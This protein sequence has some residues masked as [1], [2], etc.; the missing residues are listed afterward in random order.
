MTKNEPRWDVR[1]DGSVFVSHWRMTA[2]DISTLASVNHLTL[3]NVTFPAAFRFAEL[4]TLAWLDIRGGSRH[5]LSY[6]RGAGGLRGL[7]INQ[8]RGL[9]DLGAI[10]E[11]TG[12][13]V[14]ALY[15]LAQVE[16]LPD[17]SALTSL[18][19][20]E[21]GQLR[22]LQDWRGLASAPA[23]EELAFHNLLHPDL[24]VIDTLSAHPMLREFDWWA[25]DVPAKVQ[26]S[27]QDRLALP[28]TRAIRPEVW[29]AENGTD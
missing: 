18:R 1:A 27:V 20:L 28:K 24:G 22:N 26:A 23:L 12:L 15:G 6:L 7:S 10:S 19:R 13:R 29:F 3:W 17:L 8:I 4:T 9:A 11:L 14:L 16:S 2:K 21:L 5:D 25:P